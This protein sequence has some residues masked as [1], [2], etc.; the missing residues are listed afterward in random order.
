[1]IEVQQ[2]ALHRAAA[3]R[4]PMDRHHVSEIFSRDAEAPTIPVEQPDVAAAVA[5]Q[6][7]VPHMC[8]AMQDRNRAPA[9]GALC[10]ARRAVEQKRIEV[11]SFSRQAVA[12]PLLEP[13]DLALELA[14]ILI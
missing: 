12:E 3:V 10:E 1:M 2:W 7:A 11:S 8:I 13:G 9:V 4:I 5:W 14:P 6:E